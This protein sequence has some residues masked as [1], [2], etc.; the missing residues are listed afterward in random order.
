MNF[1]VS[2]SV[3]H[4]LDSRAKELISFR[5]IIHFETFCELLFN[6]SF[7][8]CSNCEQAL[9]IADINQDI[10]LTDLIKSQGK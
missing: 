3:V 9:A 6:L 1:P 5:K 7:S 4:T 2:R 10:T 8:V